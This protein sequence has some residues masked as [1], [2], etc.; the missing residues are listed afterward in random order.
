M[1]GREGESAEAYMARVFHAIEL[2][3]EQHTPHPVDEDGTSPFG[4][5]D[6]AA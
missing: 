3:L 2:M 4:D 1:N 5:F 6:D